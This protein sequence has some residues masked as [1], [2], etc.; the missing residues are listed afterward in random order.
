MIT[1][2]PSLLFGLVAAPLPAADSCYHYWPAPVSL[3]GSVVIRT[4]PGPPNYTSI[5]KGD[6]PQIVT[7]LVLDAPLCTIGDPAHPPNL[8]SATGQDTVQIRTVE[9]LSEEIRRRAGHRIA[10]SGTLSEA[11]IASDR[12]AVILEPVAIHE[13]PARSRSGNH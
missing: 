5:A 2:L 11:L 10:V 12:T 4:L 3:T 1:L 7:L 6:R 13:T 9:P 8:D